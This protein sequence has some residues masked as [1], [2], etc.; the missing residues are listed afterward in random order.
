MTNL[1]L[2]PDSHSFSDVDYIGGSDPIWVIF[3]ISG[4]SQIPVKGSEGTR[5]Q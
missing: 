4:R 5:S 2:Y 3:W 1:E